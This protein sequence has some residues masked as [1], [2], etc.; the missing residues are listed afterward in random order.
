MTAT[1]LQFPARTQHRERGAREVVET[2]ES[3]VARLVEAIERSI[4]EHPKNGSDFPG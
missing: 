2:P 4:R 3:R 1:I